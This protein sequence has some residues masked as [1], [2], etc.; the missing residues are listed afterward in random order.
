LLKQAVLIKET[1]PMRLKSATECQRKNQVSVS[2]YFDQKEA[3]VALA[4]VAKRVANAKKQH[5]E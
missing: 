1:E 3:L 4:W 5:K 2:K